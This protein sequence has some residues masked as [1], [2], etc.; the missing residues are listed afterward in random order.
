MA[1]I[2]RH[3]VWLKRRDLGLFPSNNRTSTCHDLH[4]L[5]P[6]EEYRTAFPTT[7]LCQRKCRR[8]TS[9]SP[10]LTPDQEQPGRL[11]TLPKKGHCCL[12][13]SWC[14]MECHSHCGPAPSLHAHDTETGICDWQA[15]DTAGSQPCRAPFK[16]PHADLS[17][18]SLPLSLPLK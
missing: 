9:H 11:S 12:A 8:E 13:M 6:R 2:C 15:Q 17:S 3:V 18:P 4:A 5:S 14:P 16:R 7:W 10:C 1:K